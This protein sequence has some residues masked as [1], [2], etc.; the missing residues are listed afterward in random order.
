MKDEVLIE[1]PIDDMLQTRV[2]K[3]I[4][5]MVDSMKQFVKRVQI[6]AEPALMTR[7][8]KEAEPVYDAEGK[9][10]IWTPSTK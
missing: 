6:K 2:Q 8:Y 4:A 1:L 9:L 5:I 3:I 10:Q 7:W